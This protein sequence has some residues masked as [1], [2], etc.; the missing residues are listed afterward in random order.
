MGGRSRSHPSILPHVHAR[1]QP[2]PTISSIHPHAPPRP[3]KKH[4]H[5]HTNATQLLL[6]IYNPNRLDVA[7]TSGQGVFKHDHEPIGHVE[8]PHVTIKGGAITDVRTPARPSLVYICT[9]VFVCVRIY[10]TYA[11]HISP[12]LPALQTNKYQQVLVTLV[13]TPSVWK[14]L[15]LDLEFQTGSLMVMVDISIAGKVIWNG[16]QVRAYDQSI[17]SVARHRIS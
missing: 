14:S 4:T 10:F 12:N 1:N 5:A 8:F 3:P 11:C 15:Q 6:S 2:N 13:F 17:V 9:S 16:M 7:I